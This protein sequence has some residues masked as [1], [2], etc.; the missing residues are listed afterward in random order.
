MN[1]FSHPQRK[2]RA[3][4][5]SK[6]QVEFF[7]SLGMANGS[8]KSPGA[9]T[10]IPFVEEPNART[11]PTYVTDEE[12]PL[13]IY[14]TEYDKPPVSPWLKRSRCVVMRGD[15]NDP[16][17][18]QMGKAMKEVPRLLKEFEQD[19]QRRRQAAL[20]QSESSSE[21]A[22]VP[23]KDSSLSPEKDPPSSNKKDV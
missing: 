14:K 4:Q 7:A 19:Q 15:K 18:A 2:D 5:I 20:T 23:A 3:F 16:R 1:A 21:D 12:T 10:A 6:Q 8:A 17:S 22:S 9:M 11:E 13:R